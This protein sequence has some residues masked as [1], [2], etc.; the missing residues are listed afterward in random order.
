[1][2]GVHARSQRSRPRPRAQ[3][4]TAPAPS[5]GRLW[6]VRA[7]LL[8]GFCL[9]MA[10]LLTGCGGIGKA[11]L[12]WYG[13]DS[14]YLR[15]AVAGA[16]HTREP[17]WSE[18]PLPE[19]PKGLFAGKL[20]PQLLERMGFAA[21]HAICAA[22]VAP[23]EAELEHSATGIRRVERMLEELQ[24][25][26]RRMD[27]C[28]CDDAHA[29]GLREYIWRC[30]EV[31]TQFDCRPDQARRDSLQQ[32][33]RGFEPALREA[34]VPR[35]HWRLF[36]R[37]DRLGWFRAHVHSWL[38]SYG[39]SAEIFI[40]PRDLKNARDSA[41]LEKIL[42]RPEVTTVV[43]M[44]MGRE[45]L[46]VR[47]FIGGVMVL[48]L[49]ILPSMKGID[50]QLIGAL[51]RNQVDGVIARLE[52]PTVLRKPMLAPHDGPMMELDI[53]A[54]ERVDD[55]LVLVSRLS[56]L[57]YAD[58]DEKGRVLE[59][60]A[61]RVALRLGP[62]MK[63]STK[64]SD[65]GVELELQVQFAEDGVLWAAA[66]ANDGVFEAMLAQSEAHTGRRIFKL[67]GHANPGFIWRGTDLEKTW[68]QG[69]WALNAHIIGAVKQNHG[70]LSGAGRSWVAQLGTESW[71]T[72]PRV[73]T[74]L[75]PWLPR[76][77]ARPHRIQGQ[78]T[79]QGSRIRLRVEPR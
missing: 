1:M 29:I 10:G 36:G 39:R 21:D 20:D 31:G 11:E 41:Q 53:D 63:A 13:D 70:E 79:H 57:P 67:G 34:W 5:R 22:L 51:A 49:M 73:G 64:L 61:G 6:A 16:K 62:A 72:V 45:L 37:G 15:C 3:S 28:V 23:S 44:K 12:S 7:R 4:R 18:L 9:G 54:L 46:I 30:D 27:R 32:L 38:E 24:R 2:Q 33:M 50:R 26:T 58:E 52:P 25:T 60:L 14:A 43:R 69:G 17:A 48:D 66:L 35:M 59:R 65:Q 76:L 71:A 74:P 42:S 78:L 68:A 56:E 47:E 77:Q 75:A 8:W 55:G 40:Q 19:I